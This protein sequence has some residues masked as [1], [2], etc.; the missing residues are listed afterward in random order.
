MLKGG[1]CCLPKA[2]SR[3]SFE[4]HLQ[5]FESQSRVEHQEPRYSVS[6]QTTA[7]E[8]DVSQTFN[9]ALDLV[10]LGAHCT[11]RQ[12]RASAET[13]TL[14]GIRYLEHVRARARQPSAARHIVTYRN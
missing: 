8:A 5:I 11:V 7:A 14:S 6:P 12:P 2:L 1:V 10:P 9:P 4:L 3:E 13:L